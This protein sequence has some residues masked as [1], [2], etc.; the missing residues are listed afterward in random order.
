[1]WPPLLWLPASSLSIGNDKVWNGK[2]SHLD[3]SVPKLVINHVNDGPRGLLLPW[4]V[5][6]ILFRYTNY[7]E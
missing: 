3:I 4:F 5:D 2:K 7:L 6:L 1:M